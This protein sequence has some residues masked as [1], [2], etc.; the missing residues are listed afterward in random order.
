MQ[1]ESIMQAKE[2]CAMDCPPSDESII[3][4]AKR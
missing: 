3:M 4:Q 1:G 2:E